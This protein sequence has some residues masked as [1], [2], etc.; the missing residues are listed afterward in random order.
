MSTRF[1]TATRSR[2]TEPRAR[3]ERRDAWYRQP[4]VWVAAAVFGV[5][6][7]GCVW[8]IVIA[9][10]YVDPPLPTGG[11][12]ILKMPLTRPPPREGGTQP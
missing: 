5:S 9:E 4:I 7:A 11:V 2:T 1:H 12:Q 3:R 10:R 6:I 8:L